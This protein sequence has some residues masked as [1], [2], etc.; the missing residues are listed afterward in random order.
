MKKR[1]GDD[2]HQ[3]P[4][5][6]IEPYRLWFEF[7]KLALQDETLTVDAKRY[8]AWGDVAGTDF[9]DWWSAN[10]RD[11]FAVDIGVQVVEKLSPKSQRSDKELIVRIPL[12]QNPKRS[13]AQVAELLNQHGASDRL[14]DM[15]EGQFHLQVGK[16]KGGLIH[17]STRFLRNLPKVRL[18]L[19]LYRFW[20]SHPHEND[21]RRLE[22]VTLDYF[23]WADAWNAKV[24][25]RKWKRPLIE[26]PSAIRIYTEYLQKREKSGGKRL[27]RLSINLA[28]IHTI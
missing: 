10:W 26:I 14:K 27:E 3:L 2:A 23:N 6:Q 18:L 13:V 4:A 11:L 16:G 5:Q 22:L 17:P 20:L 12:Y 15:A 7:L 1:K 19:H 21:R 8:E 9:S 28:H 25:Q 24:R